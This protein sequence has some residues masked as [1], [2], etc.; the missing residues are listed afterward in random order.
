MP[1]QKEL[2]TIETF[3]QPILGISFHLLAIQNQWVAWNGVHL[4]NRKSK[5]SFTAVKVV[6]LRN[7][8]KTHAP[9]VILENPGKYWPRI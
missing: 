2:N 6:F 8:Y 7:G 9:F 3:L 1:Q 5:A 4:R